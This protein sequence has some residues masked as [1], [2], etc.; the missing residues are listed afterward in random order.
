MYYLITVSETSDTICLISPENKI[1]QFFEIVLDK[2]LT[3]LR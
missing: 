3:K 1:I 2:F